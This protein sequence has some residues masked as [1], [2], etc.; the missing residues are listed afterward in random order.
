MTMAGPF[1]LGALA[2]MLE[3][4]SKL[5]AFLGSISIFSLW[6]FFVSGVGLGVLYKRNGTTIA[7]VLIGVFL[8]FMFAVAS[9][10][11]SFMG[12]A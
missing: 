12:P 3:E 7:M 10:F 2:P 6:T 11:S 1:N 4:G 5:A 8:L 9:I